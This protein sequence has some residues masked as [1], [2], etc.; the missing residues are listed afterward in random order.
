MKPVFFLREALRALKRNAIPSFAAMATVLV[1][2]LV[3]GVFIPVVQATT[4]AANEVRGKVIADVYLKTDAKRADIE[5]VDRLLKSE[6]MISKVEFISK[7]QAYKAERERNPKAYELLGSNPLPDTFRI[8]PGNP[9]D[10]GKIRDAL[11]PSAPGGGRT[12]VDPAIDEVRNREED[13]NKILAVTNVVKITMAL[14]AGLLGIASM[15]LIA[16]T[17]RLSLYAR[18]REVEVMKLVGATDWFIRWPFVLEGVIVGLFGGV[19]AILLLAVVKIAVVD[20]LAADFALIAAPETIDFP[21]LIGLL[22]VAAVSVSAL[23][24]GLSL[25]KFLRV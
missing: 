17:I 6:P 15:L 21:L 20:P 16:N 22:L 9:D 4:G 10:I 19:V 14:L 2:V 13:T 8:T 12:V 25:R 3:L 23:G 1:T 24:S 7:D 11:A 18:R 5:R